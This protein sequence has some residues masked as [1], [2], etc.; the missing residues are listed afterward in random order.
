M[1]EGI[2]VEVHR[3]YK[4]TI[5]VSK[6]IL[7]KLERYRNLF[8]RYEKVVII[9]DENVAPLYLK[10]VERQI[11]KFGCKTQEIIIPPGESSKSLSMAEEIYH[12]FSEYNLTRSD[13]VIALG[14][15]VVGD[16]AGFCASTYLR[17]V[18]FIQ[19]PTTLLAQVDSSIGGKVGVNLTKG[20]NLVGSFYQPKSVIV[21]PRSLKT[22][23]DR[24]FN[25]GMAEVIKYG[26]IYDKTLFNKLYQSTAEELTKDLENTIATCCSIKKEVIEEDERETG[27]RKILNFGHTLGHVLET[28]F[29]YQ[30][31]THGEAVA[32]GMYHITV[33]SEKKGITKY[34][35]SDKIKEI[36]IK[37]GLP[38]TMPYL[39]QEKIEEILFRDK[40]FSGDKIT[41]VLLKEIGESVL[42]SMDKNQLVEFII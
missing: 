4:Y 12:H 33:K 31:Y 11:E 38:Y 30:K 2:N 6:G 8:F 41:L 5:D 19:I 26:C 1:V 21:D 17:G 24:I 39:E 15:G 37:N 28:Y 18:D 27:L 40:K 42:Y 9:T 7:D 3:D 14:G 20:K 29:N 13:A 16:L 22:L 36:L 34:G 23:K 25:D 32:I 35:T 10:K